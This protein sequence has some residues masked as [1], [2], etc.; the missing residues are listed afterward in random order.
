MLVPPGTCHGRH[1]MSRSVNLL[2]NQYRLRRPSE[3]HP[4]III[5]LAYPKKNIGLVV[6]ELHFLH[7][8]NRQCE[9]FSRLLFCLITT[10]SSPPFPKHQQ[11]MNHQPLPT[12]GPLQVGPSCWQSYTASFSLCL[13]AHGWC[14]W[15]EQLAIMN[16]R[17][18]FI[19]ASYCC[20]VNTSESARQ[21]VQGFSQLFCYPP[22]VYPG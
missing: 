2:Y 19:P 8:I 17:P 13:A 5:N 4:I 11:D 10:C 6:K 15:C 20:D 9:L 18:P 22:W 12:M 16:F 7:H 3:V 21:N 14:S 1:F